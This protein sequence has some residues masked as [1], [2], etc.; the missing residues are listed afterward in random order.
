MQI[1]I[2][3][4]TSEKISHASAVLGV[5]K[6][7]LVDRALLLYLDSIEKMVAL[8]K[9]MGDWEALSDEALADFERSL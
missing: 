7:E 2:Q 9:E 3:K 1:E 5:G 8:K 6:K 4:D